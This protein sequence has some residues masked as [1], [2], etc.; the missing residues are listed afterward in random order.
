VAL[1]FTGL[2]LLQAAVSPVS[3]QAV[4]GVISRV[5]TLLGKHKINIANFA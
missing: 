3:F 4:L 1:V 5:G 2:S